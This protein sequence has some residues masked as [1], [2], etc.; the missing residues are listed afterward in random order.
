MNSEAHQPLRERDGTWRRR[1]P[2][3]FETEGLTILL[4]FSK[5]IERNG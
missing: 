1:M 3:I 5:S 4:R 2:R